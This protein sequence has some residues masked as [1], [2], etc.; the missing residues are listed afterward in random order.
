MKRSAQTDA[1]SKQ[2][3][4]QEENFA[5][6]QRVNDVAKARS[7]PMAQVALAW[8]LFK[9]VVTAPIVGATKPHHL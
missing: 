1:L 5:I 7:L 6:V 3:Y 9:P 4:A 8:M 2:R